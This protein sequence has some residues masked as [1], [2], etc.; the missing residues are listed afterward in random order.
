MRDGTIGRFVFTTL[1]VTFGVTSPAAAVDLSGVY[2][3]SVP[4]ACRFTDVQT[5]T[6]FRV[7]GSCTV[8]SVAFQLSLAGTADPATGAFSVT[9]EVPGLCDLACSGTGDGEESHS[10]CTSS[11]SAC[12]GPIS[13]TKCG[14][15]VIDPLGEL[16]GRQPG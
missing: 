7:S 6:A 10:T 15:G 4:Y 14:N 12:A 5:G 13:A 1:L 16:R 3:S 8:N 2:V 11:I 9:G